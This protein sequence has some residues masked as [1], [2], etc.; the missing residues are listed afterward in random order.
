MEN[1]QSMFLPLVDDNIHLWMQGVN[2][3]FIFYF[4]NMLT[5]MTS[6]S[7]GAAEVNGYSV[8]SSEIGYIRQNLGYCPQFNMLFDLWVFILEVHLLALTLSCILYLSSQW[9]CPSIMNLLAVVLLKN[10]VT[11]HYSKNANWSVYFFLAWEQG[12]ILSMRART[13]WERAPAKCFVSIYSM[14]VK[15][16]L[17]MF[18]SLKSDESSYKVEC[19]VEE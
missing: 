17:V 14:T 15:E 16:H 10:L 19:D 18:A 11:Q 6:P 7:S 8:N 3:K 12:L 2:L 5:G 13:W 4:S 1:T 9:V